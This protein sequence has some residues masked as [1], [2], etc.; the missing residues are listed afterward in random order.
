MRKARPGTIM[1]ALWGIML[2]AFVYCYVAWLQPSRLGT[3]VSYVI[4]STLGVQCNMGRVSLSLFPMPQVSIGDL[5]LRRGSL[6]HLEFNARQASIQVSWF[7]FLR[8]KPIVRS[9]TLDSPTLDISGA[10]MQKALNSPQNVSSPEDAFRLPDIPRYVTGLRLAISNGTCRFASADGKDCLTF[11]GVNMQALIP[12]LIPGKM[13]ISADSIRYLL[14]SGIDLSARETNISVS[15]L[16]K[17][18]DEEWEGELTASTALQLGS[19]DT[20]MGRRISAPYRYFPMPQPLRFSLQS[21]FSFDAE[22]SLF[23]A[24][25]RTA[26]QAVL[27]MNGHDVPISLDIPFTIAG[28]ENGIAVSKADIRMGD[29][30]VIIDGILGGLRQGAPILKGRAQIRHFSLTRWF[31]FGRLM[32]PGLQHALDN[33]TGIFHKFELTPQGVIVPSLTATV[34]DIELKGSGS[35]TEFLKPVVRIDA[36]AKSADLNRVFTE[37]HGE[38]PDL[39]HLPPP[40]LP[41]GEATEPSPS[42]PDSIA[43]GYD[44]HI[45]ADK[46]KVMG[47]EVGGADVHVIPAPKSGTMLTIDVADVY[48]G[49]A[50]SE[51][52]IRD[53]IRVVADLKNVSLGGPSAALAG[54]P[55]LSGKLKGGKVDIEFAPGNGIEMLT[56][57]GGSIKADMED[58]A[59]SVKGS[60]PLEYREFTVDAQ[61]RASSGR[62][63]EVMPDFVNFTG[64]WDASLDANAWTIH[65]A[66]PEA[67]LGFSTSYGLPCLIREQA[68]PFSLTLK[69]T[70]LAAM[71]EDMPFDVTGRSSFDAEKGTLSLKKG[72]AQNSMLQ[73]SGNVSVSDLFKSPSV[74]GQAR[75]KSSDIRKAL[76]AFGV[77]LPAS[78][79]KKAADDADLQSEFSVS[80]GK[81]ALSKLHGTFDSNAISGDL[82][83]HWADRTFLEGRLHTPFLDIDRYLPKE[84]ADSSESPKTPLPLNFL[85]KT[86]MALELKAG[87][88][89]LLSAMLSQVSLS[90]TQKNGSLNAPVNLLFPSGGSASGFFK[91]SSP[92]KLPYADV[93]LQ[94][95]A[96]RIDM[97]ELCRLRGH[98]TVITG[99]GSADIALRTR[100]KF[101]DD[102]KRTLDGFFTFL[103]KDGAIITPP[104]LG[105]SPQAKNAS[106]RTGFKTMSMS[107]TVD[108]GIIS[109]KDFSIKDSMLDVTGG[110][111]IDLDKETIDARATITLAGIPEMPVEIKGDLFSPSTN[112]KLLG[113]LAGTVGNIGSTLFD[114]AGTI[115]TAPFRI[116]SGGR[117]LTPIE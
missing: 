71:R 40:V 66:T 69:K 88:L 44:I 73:L 79:R 54:Y 106:S 26:L 81:V 45:S 34:E 110:G 103:V 35:C 111:T 25:G 80:S 72:T 51:V 55:V 42:D 109:C 98:K 32:D 28:F 48:G 97:Q 83:Y 30:R 47:F 99:L 15:S 2:T 116:L 18:I 58:G 115:L 13:E 64:R 19:L 4:E 37:L 101:W 50:D 52:Y 8:L 114:L 92:D 84:E 17:G 105:S 27:P 36:H 16:F 65:A 93:A 60:R 85:K 6:D 56:T 87:R 39:S 62:G 86:D 33:I 112:Y 74:S 20:A 61:A 22:E 104:A 23:N 113:A 117:G 95:H 31:G 14:A 94:F 108:K 53:K 89:K 9:V 68:I 76:S 43:V 10:I 1:L 46:A 5:S 49:K 38:F 75:L 90:V 3:T 63:A 96:P 102:W 70:L 82:S 67:T 11:S 29:D 100:Q 12:S 57:L 78:K 107:G 21:S 24:V 7:S 91:A 77:E 41:L 59:I